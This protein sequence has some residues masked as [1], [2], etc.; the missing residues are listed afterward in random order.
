MGAA[1][2]MWD[3]THPME[4]P[5]TPLQRFVRLA[6]EQAPR[7]RDHYD[8]KI[9]DLA[10]TT[11]K[12]LYDL[13]RGRALNP[14]TPMLRHMSEA[15]GQPF[16]LIRKAADGETVDP[17]PIEQIDG[18]SLVPAPSLEHFA[19]EMGF[20]LIEEV[21][22]A[23]GMGA[24]Y[25]DGDYPAE[26][27]GFIPFKADWLRE[28]TRS[29]TAHL[30]VVRGSGDSMEPTVRSGDFVLI[31]TSRR[32]IDDQDVVWAIAYGQL[33]MIRRVRS[34]P[35]GG[36]LLAPDNSVVRPIE[37]YDGEMDVIGRVI[38]IGRRM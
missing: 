38:W 6:L 3:V 17:E 25:L 11:G 26:S 28:F 12:P 30:K 10:N 32:R 1:P 21:D 19:S 27:L 13:H 36:Y 31:D 4:K 24:T 2:G 7:S 29:G 18:P 8:K 16:D 22:L 35:D 34:L 23:L 9:Q 37:A 20:V 5:E 33:G 15:L 14:R